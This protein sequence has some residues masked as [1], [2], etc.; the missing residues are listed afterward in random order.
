MPVRIDSSV[1]TFQ[2]HPCFDCDVLNE[3]KDISEEFTTEDMTDICL[4]PCEDIWKKFDDCLLTPPQSPPLRLD[5]VSDLVDFTDG[6]SLSMTESSMLHNADVLHDCMW[7]GQCVE[8]NIIG[9]SRHRCNSNAIR[10]CG[11]NHTRPDTPF[12]TLSTSPLMSHTFTDILSTMSSDNSN[13]DM[14]DS[15]SSMDEDFSSGAESSSQS[16]SSSTSFAKVKQSLIND[17]SYGGSFASSHQNSKSKSTYETQ[18]LIYPKHKVQT[19]S[20]NKIRCHKINGKKIKIIKAN[21]PISSNN[22][23]N[24]SCNSIVGP[25]DTNNRIPT[26]PTVRIIRNDKHFIKSKTCL[27]SNSNN[28]SK[29]SSEQKNCKFST[30]RKAS[31]VS[32]ERKVM[33]AQNSQFLKS[34]VNDRLKESHSDDEEEEDNDNDNDS[35]SEKTPK[36][37]PLRRREHNDSERKRRDHLRNAF[38]NLKDQIPKLKSAEKRPPR[39]MILHEATTYVNHLNDKQRYLERTLNAEI[40][41]RERLLKILSNEIK[42]ESN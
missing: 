34:K 20:G 42:T 40:E 4:S 3:L 7:S 19:R 22:N 31:T 23:N 38:V 8:D 14:D 15:Q 6:D 36:V 41:K 26:V 37:G 21:S 16:S 2:T 35:N 17:H 1:F 11:R 25:K 33:F 18:S 5:L 13:D 29:D 32:S 10:I 28:C 39:I 24:N 9:C 12:N 27:D 30:R